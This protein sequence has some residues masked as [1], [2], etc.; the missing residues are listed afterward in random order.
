MSRWERLRT[1]IAEATGEKLGWVFWLR[2]GWQAWKNR[3]LLGDYLEGLDLEESW[4][5]ELQKRIP[6]KPTFFSTAMRVLF[7]DL[8]VKEAFR[9]EAMAFTAYV[10]DEHIDRGS[11]RKGLIN[12]EIK[13]ARK[14]FE[15]G[16]WN[17]FYKKF[18]SIVD[19]E[20]DDLVYGL[21][22]GYVD[23]LKEKGI[24]NAEIKRVLGT[25]ADV[26]T[27]EV[28]VGMQLNERPKLL[29]NFWGEIPQEGDLRAYLAVMNPGVVM[30]GWQHAIEKKPSLRVEIDDSRLR[31]AKI[32]SFLVRLSDDWGDREE[33]RKNGSFNLLETDLGDEFWDWLGDD[34]KKL[35]TDLKNETNGET[36]RIKLLDAL[37]KIGN[38]LSDEWS[39]QVVKIAYVAIGVGTE[40]NDREFAA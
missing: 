12:K 16:N 7:E 2:I 24:A 35:M 5:S 37:K 17:Y 20:E 25:L 32:A 33:D 26:L 23:F 34:Y 36:V 6:L 22:G 11:N 19:D 31:F 3:S 8:K 29:G 21:V 10:F 39:K 27:G 9:S 18:D 4:R 14:A 30:V 13:Q 28:M 15:E 38:D 40:V 1:S